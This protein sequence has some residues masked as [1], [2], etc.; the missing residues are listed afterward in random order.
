VVKTANYVLQILF[1]FN[2]LTVH[3][4]KITMFVY[5][6]AQKVPIRMKLINY[7]FH[8]ALLNALC[9]KSIPLYAKNA[10]WVHF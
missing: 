4:I 3:I 7:V 6:F 8:V 5:N 1:V 10:T 2:V 9:A